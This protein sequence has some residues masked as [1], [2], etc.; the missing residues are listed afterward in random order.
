MTNIEVTSPING[1]CG[2]PQ[3]GWLRR[4]SRWPMAILVCSA[5]WMSIGAVLC[6]AQDDPFA[7]PSDSTTDASNAAREAF[8]G[9][10][11]ELP[12]DLPDDVR[13]IVEATRKMNPSTPVELARAIRSML[14]LR[15]VDE[16]RFY[17]NRLAGMGLEDEQQF[18]LYEQ[19]GTEFFFDL[20]ARDELAPEGAAL[21]K[22]VLAAAHRVATDPKRMDRLVR[23]LSHENIGFRSNAFQRLKQL[24]PASTA[25]ILAVFADETRS[26]EFP[27]L[28]TA[29][30]SLGADA[31]GPL[32]GALR[33]GPAAVRVESLRALGDVPTPLARQVLYRWALAPEIPESARRLAAESLKKHVPTVP[34]KVA[35]VAYLTSCVRDY[36][37]GRVGLSH[38]PVDQVAVW[39]WDAESGQL[40]SRRIPQADAARV[41][42][43]GL[44]GDLY[45][46]D[47]QGPDSRR[48]WVVTQLEA[49][50]RLA[51]GRTPVSPEQVRRQ[52]PELT[53]EE[54]NRALQMAIDWDLVPAGVA[55]ANVLAEIGSDELFMET[56]GRPCPLV[57]A[58]LTGDRHLQFAAFDA[59]TRIDPRQPYRGSSYTMAMGV[60]LARSQGTPH[61]LVGHRRL[62]LARTFASIMSR[63]NVEGI[64]VTS[65]RELFEQAR[66]DPDVEMVFI[67]DG[68]STPYFHELVF[69][70]RNDWRTRR[71]PIAVLVREPGQ[72]RRAERVFGR[73]DRVLVLPLVLDESLIAGQVRRLRALQTPWPVT[74][75]QRYRIGRLAARWL[76]TVLANRDAYGF[77]DPFAFET[78]IV[79]GLANRPFD[80]QAARLLGRLASAAAQR[81]L[82]SVVATEGETVEHRMAAA[83]AFRQAVERNGVLLTSREIQLQYDRYNAS[84][85]LPPSS[86]Q[87]LGHVLDTLEH[88][89]GVSSRPS[90]SQ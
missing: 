30:R 66:W 9:A 40:K 21:A 41:Y 18:Q 12:A 35:A 36:L 72:K 5:L 19:L 82:I 86:Q 77:Y 34:D 54:V 64:S 13:L 50:G 16:A 69:Q 45:A 83:K 67:T 25:A 39:F 59:I 42:A 44:A 14:D 17:L 49:A 38:E 24:G 32:V 51:A 6:C 3:E 76:H 10:F 78:E 37:T 85:S 58:L 79:E 84:E 23:G 63:V 20:H 26:S 75:E 52:I 29:L 65:G 87:I 2:A 62:P 55:A 11:P 48:L 80:L 88:Q 73:D 33:S 28:R 61:G 8:S 15:Q 46:I 47:P 7:T 31:T 60:Y 90:D 53:P 71:L 1:A 74:A 4:A 22:Q 57:R 27:F 68:L 43:A 89:A 81:T 56:G 70:L